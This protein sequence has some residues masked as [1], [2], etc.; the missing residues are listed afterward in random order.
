MSMHFTSPG[1][2]LPDGCRVDSPAANAH[3]GTMSASPRAVPPDFDSLVEA[4]AQR[5]DR[6]AFKQLFAYFAP[7]IKS[8]CRRYGLSAER[9]D[10]IAQ[11]AMIAVWAK[12]GSFD[13]NRAS[14]STWIFTIAR[15]ARIDHLRREGRLVFVAEPPND[16][17]DPADDPEQQLL[18]D[19]RDQ[20]VAEAMRALTPEQAAIVRL[21]F[22][23][24]NSHSSIAKKLDLPLGTVKSRIRLALARLRALIE[25]VP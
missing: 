6:E 11:E 7:R 15:N 19:E 12:A 22:F 10:E 2:A 14:A 4:V 25:S 1:F 13:A 3:S 20:S 9:S 5:R 17:L 23:D 16:D 8:Q 21:A 24:E 18:L